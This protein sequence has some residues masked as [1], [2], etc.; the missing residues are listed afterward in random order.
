MPCERGGEEVGSGGVAVVACGPAGKVVFAPVMGDKG[1]A[2]G[3]LPLGVVK[4]D[5]PCH[6]IRESRGGHSTLSAMSND[7]P[8]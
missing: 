3:R 8:R 1:D 5:G 4:G 6:R 2:Q 7:G